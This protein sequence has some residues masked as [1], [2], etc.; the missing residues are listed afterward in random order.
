VGAIGYSRLKTFQQKRELCRV[1]HVCDVFPQSQ[2]AIDAPAAVPYITNE[3]YL[4]NKTSQTNN[5]ELLLRSMTRLTNFER[6]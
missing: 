6:S 1:P 5:W 2:I 3:P 4:H